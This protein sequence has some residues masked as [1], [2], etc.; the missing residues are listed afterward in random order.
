MRGKS[1]S[2]GNVLIFIWEAYG[3]PATPNSA[4]YPRF[5]LAT[6]FGIANPADESALDQAIS[7]IILISF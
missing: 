5:V 6:P 1:S 2:D 7:P 3:K 4:M